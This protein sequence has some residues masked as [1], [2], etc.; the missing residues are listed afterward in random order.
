MQVPPVHGSIADINSVMRPSAFREIPLSPEERQIAREKMRKNEESQ[1]S[2]AA[3]TLLL[4]STYSSHFG[5]RSGHLSKATRSP[6]AKLPKKRTSVNTKASHV[7]SRQ[8]MLPKA[9]KDNPM[10]RLTKYNASDDFE[11]RRAAST[12]MLIKNEKN[13]VYWQ[14]HTGD[15]I[16]PDI[17]EYDDDPP[18]DDDE[19]TIQEYNRK[20]Q[21]KKNAMVLRSIKIDEDSEFDNSNSMVP[22]KGERDGYPRNWII[23]NTISSGSGPDFDE[24]SSSISMD[25]SGYC[26]I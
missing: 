21:A 10:R 6:T 26:T 2:T 25:T 13:Y 14:A 18:E 1:K 11:V 9:L 8:K 22:G 15:S 17:T 19:A 20:W 4:F 7:Q 24:V 3:K 12:L 5:G 16:A 23:G